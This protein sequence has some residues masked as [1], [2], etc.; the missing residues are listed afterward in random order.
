MPIEDKDGEMAD[1]YQ[2]TP[3]ERHAL[4]MSVATFAQAR[5]TELVAMRSAIHLSKLEFDSP[6]LA[7][8]VEQDCIDYV[9][10]FLTRS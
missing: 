3:E 6:E 8:V 1:G 4:D 7:A 9:V 5:A 2:P 10:E